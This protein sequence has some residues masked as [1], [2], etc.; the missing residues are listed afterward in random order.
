MSGGELISQVK[1]LFP[2]IDAYPLENLHITV[3]F[4]GEVENPVLEK[5]YA[6]GSEVAKTIPPIAFENK[7]LVVVD[8]RLR[9]EMKLTPALDDLRDLINERLS[10]ENIGK[11]DLRGYTPHVTLARVPD[12]FALEKEMTI[13][14]TTTLDSFGLYASEPGLLKLGTYTL[15]K[16]FPLTGEERRA[17]ET[18]FTTIIL[19][20]KSQPDT[21]V[22]VYILKT[23]GKERFPGI[24]DAEV[25]FWH[26]LPDGESERSLKEKGVVLIDIGAGRFDHHHRAE[27]TTATDLI[28]GF[29]DLSQDPSLQKLI[30]YARRDD[31]FGKGT[32]STDPLDRAFG[33]SGLIANLNRMHQGAP[34]KVVGSILPLIAAHH[35]EEVRRTRELPEEFNK[36]LANGEAKV[37]SVKQ[38]DKKLRVIAIES[39]NG[40][41]SGFL[42]SQNG[43]RHDVVLQR[44]SSGHA[45]ILTRPT[46][47]VDLRSLAAL[48]RMQEASLHGLKSTS[49]AWHLAKMGRI[50]EAPNWYYDTATNSIQNGGLNPEGVEPTAIKLP[51]LMKILEAGLSEK[52]W[53]PMKRG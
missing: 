10:K 21:L 18:S 33:L 44:F 48:I 35:F 30:E 3:Q 7:R 51:A 12:E 2:S 38:R 8:G 29:L 47:R 45:N 32:I 40:S 34:E 17:S 13:P 16:S 20:A 23:Y 4:V 36:K 27:K 53:S 22:A 9:L 37:F 43:G 1:N 41:M 49:N 26:T 42:R 31:F 5:L 25:D 19:P 28:C 46:K 14:F 15:L 11:I 52:L 50:D 39:D 6:I 24:E